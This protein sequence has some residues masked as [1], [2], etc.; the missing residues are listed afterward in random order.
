MKKFIRLIILSIG[1]L[2]GTNSFA[3]INGAGFIGSPYSMNFEL[4]TSY[5]LNQNAY[6][7]SASAAM[8][9][10]KPGDGQTMI[11]HDID[12]KTGRI[13][14]YLYGENSTD[15][16]QI[17]KQS[18]D[19]EQLFN[20]E[21][22]SLEDILKNGNYKNLI[23]GQRFGNYEFNANPG[24]TQNYIQVFDLGVLYNNNKQVQNFLENSSN[25]SGD[26][27]AFSSSK[28]SLDSYT[29]SERVLSNILTGLITLNPDYFG[30]ELVNPNGT[31]GLKDYAVFGENNSV[32]ATPS[33][34][35]FKQVFRTVLGKNG[36]NVTGVNVMTLVSFVDKKFWGFYAYLIYN[37]KEAYISI[38]GTM[39]LFG[40]GYALG[41]F[42]YRKVKNKI[43]KDDSANDKGQV[44]SKSMDIFLVIGMFLIPISITQSTIPDTFIYTKSNTSIHTQANNQESQDLFSQSTLSSGVIR[45]FANLGSTWA[46]VVND[47]ALFSYL[48]FLESKQKAITSAGL[49]QNEDA[50]KKLY[51]DA[52]YLKKEYDFYIN[53]CRSAFQPILETTTRFNS[54]S[55]ES[56]ESF[57]NNTITLQGTPIFNYLGYTK[58]NPML[59][60][61]IEESIATTTKRILADYSRVSVEIEVSKAIVENYETETAKQFN[62]YLDFMQF[63]SNNYGWISVAVVPPS[64]SLLFGNGKSIFSYDVAQKKIANND[65][66]NLSQTFAGNVEELKEI[67]DDSDGGIIVKTI[68]GIIS[69]TMW[70]I[71][72]G[73][74][75]IFN[76]F[77]NY[78]HNATFLNPTYFQQTLGKTVDVGKSIVDFVSYFTGPLGK[79][80]G[81]GVKLILSAIKYF[82]APIIYGA[83]LY[84]CL[85][86]TIKIYTIM[87]TTITMIV[88]GTAITIKVCLY[89][90]ELLLY[91]FLTDAIL[92][93]SIV[94]QKNEYF[95]KFLSKG[96]T[97]T[98]LTPLLI[99]LSVYVFIFFHTLSK[100]LYSMLMSTIYEVASFQQT[101]VSSNSEQGVVQGFVAEI[102]IH[103]YQSFGEIVI[104][105]FALVIGVVTIFKFKDWVFKIVGIEDSDFS[106][107]I[108]EGLNNKITG[109]VN[110]V[111]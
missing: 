20:A 33:D 62:Y 80:V 35:L 47:Y 17:F 92:F 75:D 54:I 63:V 24:Y 107:S 89:F 82:S 44:A 108:S 61:K 14:C 78:A 19:K 6:L 27:S 66:N 34:N 50:I 48:R 73:F 91:Y 31:I 93:I 90:M 110:P 65:G 68:G 105:I 12:P 1:I 101:N 3:N 9:C 96:M 41:R 72:P 18:G 85:I 74:N 30:N 42:G 28:I 55:N 60:V 81:G 8:S 36:D 102:T 4:S 15:P 7:S 51:I 59:C 95:T 58:I 43:N 79:L 10:P 86:I 67:S 94:T 56:K 46:N 32:G 70:F 99:V 104:T 45:Y 11:L 87:I 100:E 39:M 40:G 111:K 25:N 98:L 71:L 76:Q 103:S 38:L 69:N 64:Y 97:I 109:G 84:L 22:I 13:V 37:L 23:I 16:I 77:H 83:V 52:F 88:M 5:G 2:F 29:H 49:S 26:N 57:L 106:S 21:A 53:V